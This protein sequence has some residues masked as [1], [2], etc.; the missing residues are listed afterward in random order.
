[1]G[2]DS[3]SHDF[4]DD[5]DILPSCNSYGLSGE[6]VKL[7]MSFSGGIA[8]PIV[9]MNGATGIVRQINFPITREALVMG[10]LNKRVQWKRW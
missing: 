8:D 10:K 5:G 3:Q 4:L 9:D 2:I 6:Q 1:M 7:P